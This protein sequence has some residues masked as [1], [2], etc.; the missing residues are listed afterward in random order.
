MPAWALGVLKV[1]G[2]ALLGMAASLITED[3]IRKVVIML[4]EKLVVRTE[5]DLDNKLL[6]EAKKAWDKADASEE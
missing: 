4:L 3:M 2:N 1:A 6:E 5:T